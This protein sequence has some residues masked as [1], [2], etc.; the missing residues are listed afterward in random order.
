L[1]FVPCPTEPYLSDSSYSAAHTG[2]PV[3][4][5]ALVILSSGYN[6]ED[7]AARFAGSGLAGFLQKPYKFEDLRKNLIF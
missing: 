2:L 1:R 7:A 5:D 6:E 3:Q 4:S